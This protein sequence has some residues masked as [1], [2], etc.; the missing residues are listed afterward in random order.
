MVAV[1]MGSFRLLYHVMHGA[2]D[3]TKYALNDASWVNSIRVY[4]FVFNTFGID[5]RDSKERLTNPMI[6]DMGL[7][8]GVVPDLDETEGAVHFALDRNLRLQ[9]IEGLR[10]VQYF[11]SNN[12]SMP[13]LVNRISNTEQ[14]KIWMNRRLGRV[15]GHFLGT[16]QK[17]VLL[18]FSSMERK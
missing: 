1:N 9:G 8:T 4:S 2:T 10:L 15:C 5:E 11:C 12:K 16:L 18:S 13:R 7:T 6:L 17:G 3:L 14:R